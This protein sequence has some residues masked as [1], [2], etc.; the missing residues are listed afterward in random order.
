MLAPDREL[1]VLPRHRQGRLQRDPCTGLEGWRSTHIRTMHTYITYYTCLRV[2]THMHT[3]F[4]YTH[5]HTYTISSGFMQLRG[6]PEA[7]GSQ[8][9]TRFSAYCEIKGKRT[10]SGTQQKAVLIFD[11][12]MKGNLFIP[13][14]GK[15][16]R[17]SEQ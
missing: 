10:H 5:T 16:F 3:T 17:C 7:Q 4:T 6:K 9:S 15:I 12:A 11:Q 1:S 2:Y 8:S 13:P 14:P